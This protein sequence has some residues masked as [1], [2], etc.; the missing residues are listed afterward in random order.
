[1]REM[2]RDL[3]VAELLDRPVTDAEYEAL[4]QQAER[5]LPG[6]LRMFEPDPPK[7]PGSWGFPN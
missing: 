1:M 3:N 5:D 6:L 7:P 4:M 2:L